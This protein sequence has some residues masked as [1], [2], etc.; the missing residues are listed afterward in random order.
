METIKL[1]LVDDHNLFREGVKSLL[2]KMPDIELVLE[3]VSGEDLLTKLIDTIPDVVLL[4]LEMEDINGVDV[5]IRLQQLYP[6]I[7]IIILTMHKEERI[8]SYLMEIGAN[9]YL[10]KDTNGNELHEAIKSVH[11]KEFYFN[12]LVSQALLNGCKN[13]SNKPPVIG[14]NYK[15]T[16]RELE[17]LELIAQELTT[18]E[19]AD[20]LFL[21]VRTI[22]GHRKNLTSKL[23]VKNTAGL[24]LKAIKDKIIAI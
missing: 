11:E 21:S 5:T 17:V 23:E 1:G 6:E 12:A 19:I 22:E 18:V 10:L 24:I 14:K 13:K 2:D 7:K 3:A 4:D 15:L 8:I 16:S 9:G 20:K